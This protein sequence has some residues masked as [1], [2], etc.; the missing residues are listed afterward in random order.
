M[1]ATA[2]VLENPDKIAFSI[3]S[4][5]L[6]VD[7]STKSI[8]RAIARGDLQAKDHGGRRLIKREALVAWVDGLPDV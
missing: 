5:A 7:V 2:R 6:A 4:A 1:S 3:R 8:Q